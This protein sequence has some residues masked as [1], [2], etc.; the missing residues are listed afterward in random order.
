MKPVWLLLMSAVSA[1]VGQIFFKRGVLLT[2]EM[3]FKGSMLGELVKL[4]FNPVVFFGLIFY[5]ASTLLCNQFR[6]SSLHS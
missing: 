2:G 3:T 1:S 4:I 5:V 6:V